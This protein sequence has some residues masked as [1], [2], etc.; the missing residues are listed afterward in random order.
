MKLKQYEFKIEC[1][2]DKLCL[3]EAA[4]EEESKIKMGHWETT[5]EKEIQMNDW[6]IISGP[7]EVK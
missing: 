2:I 6:S 7:R 5:D 4:N 3:I 1:T